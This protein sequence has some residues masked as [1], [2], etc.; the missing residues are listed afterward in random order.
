MNRVNNS[1]F[2]PSVHRSVDAERLTQIVNCLGVVT[3]VEFVEMPKRKLHWRRAF[4]HFVSLDYRIM[5]ETCTKLYYFTTLE[6]KDNLYTLYALFNRRSVQPTLPQLHEKCISFEETMEGICKRIDALEFTTQLMPSKPPPIERSTNHS[7]EQ[8]HVKCSNMESAIDEL[9]KKIDTLENKA[10]IMPPIPPPIQRSTNNPFAHL[11][12][13]SWPPPEDIRN[14]MNQSMDNAYE[15]EPVVVNE[16]IYDDLNSEPSCCY[17]DLEQGSRNNNTC[18]GCFPLYQPNQM[19]HMDP[20]GCLW[21]ADEEVILTDDETSLNL[22]EEENILSDDEE[23]VTDSMPSLVAD[24]DEESV[25]SSMPALVAIDDDE[26]SVASSMPAL[27]AI[28]DDEESVSSSMPSLVPID[29][30]L[31]NTYPH[32]HPLSPNFDFMVLYKNEAKAAY[33]TIQNME[34][35]DYL[36]NYTTDETRGFMFTEDPKIKALSDQIQE[37][38]GGMHSGYSLALTLRFMELIAKQG[39]DVF[40]DECIRQKM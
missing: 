6:G 28:D 37:D 31:Q 29:E 11:R 16:N 1:I 40:R 33:Q 36:Y 23:S 39:F 7:Y 26:E 13:D 12:Y 21:V 4:V 19:A 34:M 9:Y 22:D 17:N 3:R 25:S 24:D 38:Y 18:S 10:Q 15:N 32:M 35:W 27:V 5:D 30:E 20:G 2:I 14:L 8:L